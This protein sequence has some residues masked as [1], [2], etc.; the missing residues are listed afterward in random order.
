[1]TAA[2]VTQRQLARLERRAAKAG[3]LPM[4][5]SLSIEPNMARMLRAI[6]KGQRRNVEAIIMDSLRADLFGGSRRAA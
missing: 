5:V 3:N 1:M 2:A 4:R 6:A